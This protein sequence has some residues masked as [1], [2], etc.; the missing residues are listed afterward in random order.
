ME[1][2]KIAD[3][4]QKQV[5][6]GDVGIAAEP[7]GILPD[8]V[9]VQQG[10]NAVA[11]VAAAD[12]PHAVDGFVA[13]GAVDVLRPLGVGCGEIAVP[14]GKIA[15]GV[16]HRLHAQPT[17]EVKSAGQFFLRH[18]GGGGDQRHSGAGKKGLWMDHGRHLE[19][20]Y[21]ASRTRTR[22]LL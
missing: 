15:G 1:S 16:Q 13:E 8:S 2:R 20:K 14:V 3:L 5:Q 11:A 19:K 7:L 6:G 4:I 12:A 10:E 17:D 21:G 22:A 9:R 18:G